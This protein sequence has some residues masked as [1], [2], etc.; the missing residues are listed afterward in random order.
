MIYTLTL[1]PA[2]D[3]V[4]YVDELKLGSINRSESERI[5]AGGKGINVSMI[6]GE[7]G[8]ASVAMGFL[9]GFTG[10]AIEKMLT[11][12][13]IVCDFVYLERGMTRIN[14]KLRSGCE[15]DINTC[16]A[17]VSRDEVRLLTEKLDKLT[18]GDTLVLAG[19]IPPSL[20]DDIYEKI[21]ARLDGRGIRF[22]VDAA[23]ELLL[24]SLEY[25]P[26]L[27][28]PNTDELGEIFGVEIKCDE[29]A[30]VYAR[31][32]RERGARNVLV[33]MGE[34]GALLLDEK[35]VLHRA[36]AHK[37]NVIN[38]VGAG[39]SMVAGFIAGYER[40]GDYDSALSLGSAAGSATAFS[41]GLADSD[42]I[43]EVMKNR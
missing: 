9:A 36:S 20:P 19:S 37:G 10:N 29:D 7:L 24:K 1:N 13:G 25:K 21:M 41:E 6:L 27:I 15:T 2:L 3:Y 23:G 43:E 35:G 42:M 40:S 12:K 39:D 17:E 32:L 8:V 33:S 4:V 34:D 30:A 22:V 16:G 31:K 11:D 28:K 14:I 38:T 26:F 5:F 18:S